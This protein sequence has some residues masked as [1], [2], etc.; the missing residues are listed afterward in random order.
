MPGAKLVA[1]WAMLLALPNTGS[2][3]R[4]RDPREATRIDRVEPAKARPGD[5]V[6]IYGRG[7]ER[8]KIADV[9][10]TDEDHSALTHILDQSGTLIRVRLPRMLEPGFYS[11][12]LA[13]SDRETRFLDQG[14]TIKVE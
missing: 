12:V 8:S 9:L 5:I 3:F 2:T 13:T 11:I 4:D 1:A 6:M 10:L 14:V 7:L